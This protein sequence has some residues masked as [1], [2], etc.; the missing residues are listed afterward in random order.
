M[1]SNLRPHHSWRVRSRAWTHGRLGLSQA[2]DEVALW[3]G[4]PA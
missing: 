1:G 4:R 2:C 3:G